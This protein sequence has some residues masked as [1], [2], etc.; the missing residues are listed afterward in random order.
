LSEALEAPVELQV[1]DVLADRI[2]LAEEQPLL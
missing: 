2:G 1:D